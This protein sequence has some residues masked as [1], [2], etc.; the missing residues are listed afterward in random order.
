MNYGPELTGIAPY[1]SSLAAGLAAEGHSVSVKTT[2]PHY[3][4]WIIRAGYGEWHRTDHIAGVRVER[5]R[6]YVP[7]APSSIKRLFSELSFGLRLA[8][9]RWDKPDVI[10][11]VSPALFSSAIANVKKRVLYRRIP[12]VVWVQ[13]LY[14]LGVAETGAAPG[15]IAKFVSAAES[16]LLRSATG[17]AVIHERFAEHVV[18]VLQVTRART[19]VVRNWTHLPTPAAGSHDE[20]RARLG[21]GPSEVIALHA[22]NIGVKQALENLV[23]AAR[24]A[25]AASD[26]IRFVLLGKGN[27]RESV[28]RSAAGAQRVQ[29]IDPLPG[30]D[31]Q[32]AMAAADVLIVNEK[33]G[34][35]EMAV[36]SKLTSYF[37]TG[38][39]VI[40]ATDFGSITADEIATSA[41]GV[42]VNAEDPAALLAAVRKLA[43]DPE[44]AAEYGAN[45]LRFRRDVLSEQ[46]AVANFAS[47]LQTLVADGRIARS[48]DE[49]IVVD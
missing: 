18:K 31:F 19:K 17:V 6:H 40:A 37:S 41:A 12:S 46:S 24:L 1:T 29:F 45:G 10:I 44:S 26:N 42:R 14:G 33:R 16:R 47:W 8:L 36:P 13:D 49:P 35:A 2:H 28:E 39:P 32:D 23:D 15:A 3:P 43:A 4:E 7:A 25:D 9:T 20:I 34:L 48:A 5:L 11:M 21:W 22:G 30:S 27:R 38:L